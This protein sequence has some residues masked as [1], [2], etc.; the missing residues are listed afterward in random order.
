MVAKDVLD[1]GGQGYDSPASSSAAGGKKNQTCVCLALRKSRGCQR[2]E[3]PDVVG[4]YRSA[5]TG[6][7][8][9]ESPVAASYEVGAFGDGDYVRA[10]LA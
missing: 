8:I 9:E 2:A 3:V 7:R 10:G 4:D 1:F 5:F 6:R